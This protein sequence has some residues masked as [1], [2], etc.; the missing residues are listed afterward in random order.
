M[1]QFYASVDSKGR[2]Y[3]DKLDELF[4]RRENGFYVELG[5]FNGVDYSN[6]AFFEYT[7][8]WK[9]ILVEPSLKCY[10]ECVKNRPNSIC[11]NAACV[12]NEYDL[13]TIRGDFNNITMA[14]VDGMRLNTSDDLLVTVPALTLESIFNTHNVMN[15]DF[16]SLDVENYELHILK[17]INFNKYRPTYILVEIYNNEYTNIINYLQENG[18]TVLSNFS[19]FNHV[20]N[21]GWDGTHQ[22]YLFVDNSKKP[23]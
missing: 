2:H 20:D 11:I 15:I 8:K 14:S 22:D 1:N 6:T 10:E 3:D 7:R 18:Y 17:G 4:N 9:G 21:P 19:N 13:P 16:L 12:S 5:A 23:S